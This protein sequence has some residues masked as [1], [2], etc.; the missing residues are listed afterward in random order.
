MPPIHSILLT[1]D[2]GLRRQQRAV[3]AP[4]PVISG[5]GLQ[6]GSLVRV[7]VGNR[8]RGVW[9]H[10]ADDITATKAPDGTPVLYLDA[11]TAAALGVAIDTLTEGQIDVRSWHL[12]PQPMRLDYPQGSGLVVVPPDVLEGL[13]G[14]GRAVVIRSPSRVMVAQAWTPPLPDRQA[15]DKVRLNY[16][17]RL[18]LG[19]TDGATEPMQVTPWPRDAGIGFPALAQRAGRRARDVMGAPLRAW[20]GAPELL[21]AVRSASS[22][23]D[24]QRVARCA[25]STLDLLGARPGD[26]V[27]VGWG[28]RTTSVRLFPR[29][30]SDTSPINA[31]SMVDWVGGRTDDEIPDDSEILIPAAVRAE[32][33]APRDSVVLVRRSTAWLLRK[34]AVALT[35]PLVGVAISIPGVDLPPVAGVLLLAL[36]SLMTLAQDRVPRPRRRVRLGG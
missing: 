9:L 25:S 19:I 6:A 26:L 3:L 11:R 15:P 29:S 23:D 28:P 18:L 32:L 21:V 10:V 22:I 4:P 1:T 27:R 16:H 34:R 17:S 8:A 13:G 31:P 20:L 33:G 12:R 24:G 30:D 5:W 36:V 7:Q 14:T 2:A 35:L